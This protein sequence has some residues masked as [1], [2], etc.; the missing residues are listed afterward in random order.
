VL[1]AGAEASAQAPPRGEPVGDEWS[2]VFKLPG[3]G[4]LDL[5]NLSGE[6]V[7]VGGAGDEIRVSAARQEGRRHRGHPESDDVRIVVNEGAGRVEIRTEHPRR[8]GHGDVDFTVHVPVYTDLN[9]RSVS[10]EVR[11]EKVQGEVRAESVSGSVTV[12]DVGKLQL[13]K[14]VSGEVT[15]SGA[16]GGTKCGRAHVKTISGGIEYGGSFTGG[17]RYE[18]S[19]HSGDVRL[20]VGTGAGF[21]LVAKTF[22][23][24]L[25]TDVPMTGLSDG[26]GPSSMPNRRIRG[27]VGDGSAYVD[28]KTFSGSVIVTRNG[29]SR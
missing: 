4:S 13:A 18:F 27:T 17:G 14:S 12:A 1:C 10:G 2:R 5:G 21:E 29:A 23:G 8:G 28:V 26:G 25:Q 24:G 16:G 9:I 3:K 19:S 6:I 7:V 11:I 20:I 22:S 15:V